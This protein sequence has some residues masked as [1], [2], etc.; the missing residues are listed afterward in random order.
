MTSR[1]KS[2]YQSTFSYKVKI[3]IVVWWKRACSFREKWFKCWT[4]TG[5][6]DLFHWQVYLLLYCSSFWPKSSTCEKVSSSNKSW[7]NKGT[8]WRHQME[9]FSPYLAPVDSP[10]KGQW[11]EAL[12]FSLIRHRAYFDVTV[13]KQIGLSEA[14]NWFICSEAYM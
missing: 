6:D 8:W 4:F 1:C 7:N 2:F 9:T 14:T 12:I 10:H 13:I 11:H 3:F 5:Q